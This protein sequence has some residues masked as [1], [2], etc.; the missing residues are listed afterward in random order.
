MRCGGGFFAIRRN[1]YEFRYCRSG[2]C[3]DFANGKEGRGRVTISRNRVSIGRPIRFSAV[4][5][6]HSGPPVDQAS[7]SLIGFPV[8]SIGMGRP[9]KS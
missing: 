1:S 9:V 8:S 6:D 2:I 3:Q 4:L 7:N 5:C